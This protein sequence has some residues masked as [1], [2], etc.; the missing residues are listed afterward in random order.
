MRSKINNLEKSIMNYNYSNANYAQNE[1]RSLTPIRTNLNNNDYQESKFNSHDPSNSK[2]KRCNY[3]YRE[4]NQNSSI[5]N[6][7][8]ENKELKE[9]L[10]S[11]NKSIITL[12][13]QII[14]LR[15]LNKTCYDLLGQL[16]I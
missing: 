13:N 3:D 12:E 1:K 11:K 9:D 4:Q 14:E 8:A 5:N 16:N 6:F 10:K 7:E 2:D 15:A